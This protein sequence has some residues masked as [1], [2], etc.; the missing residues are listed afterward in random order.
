MAK[1]P[2]A[3]SVEAATS[4]T[5]ARMNSS[6]EDVRCE[7]SRGEEMGNLFALEVLRDKN[8]RVIHHPMPANEPNATVATNLWMAL[9]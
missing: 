7:R 8:H 9:S 1:R 5:I 6:T 4:D 3:T 2:N